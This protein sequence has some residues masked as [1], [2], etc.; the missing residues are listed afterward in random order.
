MDEL[1]QQAELMHQIAEKILKILA[2]LNETTRI[3][4][5]NY[6]F[7]LLI[8]DN[9]KGPLVAKAMAATFLNNVMNSINEYFYT[10]DD[11]CEPIH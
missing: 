4:V 1:A 7:L 9:K 8:L 3:A 11:E 10:E 6:I 2:R 5:I